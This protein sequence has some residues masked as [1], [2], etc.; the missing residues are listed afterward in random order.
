M[1]TTTDVYAAIA[2]RLETAISG[3]TVHSGTPSSLNQLPAAVLVPQ[4]FNPLVTMGGVAAY[5][6]TVLLVVYVA[7]ADSEQAWHSAQNYLDPT[8]SNSVEAALEGDHTLGGN[9]FTCMIRQG[10]ITQRQ[11]AGGGEYIVVEFLLEYW[12]N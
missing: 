3:L 1:T 9:V 11:T 4:T 12:R 10:E 8:G 5:Q 2:S 6:Y 7:S